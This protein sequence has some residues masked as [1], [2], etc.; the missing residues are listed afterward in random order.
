MRAVK[1]SPKQPGLLVS[2]RN[3]EEAIAALAGG[4]DVID[5]KEPNNGALGAASVDVVSA[6]VRVVEGRAMVTAALGEL[7][8]L[9]IAD[10]SV[11]GGVIPDGVSLFK[12]GLAGCAQEID[13]P[14]RWKTIISK[15]AGGSHSTSAQPVAVVYADWRAARA[16]DPGDVLKIGVDIGCPALLIDT[17]DKSAGA[18]FDHWQVEDLRHYINDVRKHKLIVVLAGSLI[19]NYYQLAASIKPDFVAVRGAACDRGRSGA[20][21]KERVQM[22]KAV[23]NS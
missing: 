16:P 17:W 15:F 22:L 9:S 1:L 4:A 19:G 3:A 8:D 7:V 12:L 14:S 2:V 20:V 13:W 5:V 18:L 21:S 23:L 6:I 10:R 11:E